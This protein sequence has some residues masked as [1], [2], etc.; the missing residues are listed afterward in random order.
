MMAPLNVS[1]RMPA[2]TNTEPEEATLRN[3]VLEP[4]PSGV[5]REV[6]VIPSGEVK[7]MP[8]SP[9]AANPD[10]DQA[11]DRRSSRQPK[12]QLERAVHV[13]PSGEV[14]IPPLVPTATNRLLP[15]VKATSGGVPV[16]VGLVHE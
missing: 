5:E 2:A 13:I 9:T 8:I 14:E 6:H 1:P 12:P 7:T 15:K 11:T 16:S 10:P 4:V 3:F